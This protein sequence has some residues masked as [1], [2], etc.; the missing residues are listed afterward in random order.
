MRYL[1]YMYNDKIS[2]NNHERKI[3]KADLDRRKNP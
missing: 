3:K 1:Y 2:I